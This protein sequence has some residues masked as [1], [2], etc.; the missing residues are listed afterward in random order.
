M[1]LL[2]FAVVLIL[3]L[4]TG[5]D[6]LVWKREDLDDETMDSSGTC[7]SG[8]Q[9]AAFLAP[10]VAV[11]LLALLLLAYMAYKTRDV[12]EAYSE[13]HW[14]YILIIMQLEV[15][16]VAS[17]VVIKLHDTN[18]IPNVN[19]MVFTLLL[20]SFPWTTLCFIF[21]PKLL[22]YWKSIRGIDPNKPKRG[23]LQSKPR[24]TGLEKPITAVPSMSEQLPG[25]KWAI[26]QDDL[27]DLSAKEEEQSVDR[28]TQ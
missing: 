1:A 26:D 13:S 7:R 2:L 22:A 8:G 18:P 12:D 17:P 9:L 6:P 19:Y 14:I 20:L 21:G 28:N 15:V 3:S 24:V 5:L 16:L 11:L 10:F 27:H 25:E 23:Q 4:W